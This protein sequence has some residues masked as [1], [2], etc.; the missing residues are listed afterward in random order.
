MALGSGEHVRRLQTERADGAAFGAR[1]AA[2]LG[3]E[4]S[5]CATPKLQRSWAQLALRWPG[6]RPVVHREHFQVKDFETRE[7]DVENDMASG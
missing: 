7:G 3:N 6:P 2:E 1:P 5:G 4:C